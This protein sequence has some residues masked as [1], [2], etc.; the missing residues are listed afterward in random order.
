MTDRRWG[1]DSLTRLPTTVYS[2]AIGMFDTTG[3]FEILSVARRHQRRG[4]RGIEYG[5]NP[6]FLY[7]MMIL[8]KCCNGDDG[9]YVSDES[10][11]CCWRKACIL[12][13]SFNYDINNN[14]GG[15][16]L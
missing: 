16:T 11:C 7:C 2:E 5:V 9:E 4:F 13:V 14:A 1:Q 6:N 12:P 10:T 8:Q 3:G 15:E